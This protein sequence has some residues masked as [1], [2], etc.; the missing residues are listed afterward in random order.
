MARPTSPVNICNL[1]LDE[2]K[3][4]P[5]VS[6]ETPRSNSE[7]IFARWYDTLR[8]ESLRAHPW[9]C[10]TKRVILTPDTSD[11]PPFG[12]TYA[13]NLPSDWIRN[14]S[15]GDDYLKD[16]KR[17]FVVEDGQILAPAGT[18][19]SD[20]ISLY[21][22]YVYDL[23][24]VAQMDSLFISYLVL[25]LANKLSTKFSVSPTI[26]QQIKED[27]RDI[28]TEAKA[29]NGQDAPI[30]RVQ[31]SRILTKR[32]GMPGGIFASKY[33]IFDS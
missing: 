24:N 22:R 10:A 26:K 27:F 3:Q 29:V 8:Q 32:R 23:T 12:Y 1:A 18:S 31:Y 4:G 2:L 30:K 25:N 33:T 17:D 13:Y 6:I 28:Q 14:V 11:D 20:G 7:F 21:L 19:S 9:K 16:L 5:I 15:I